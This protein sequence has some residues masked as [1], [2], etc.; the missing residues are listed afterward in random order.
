MFVH[1]HAND[2]TDIHTQLV[3]ASSA[4]RSRIFKKVAKE[5][6]TQMFQKNHL[7]AETKHSSI[8]SKVDIFQKVPSISKQRLIIEIVTLA[9]ALEIHRKIRSK[10]FPLS[11]LTPDLS[12]TNLGG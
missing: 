6:F 3:Y 11:D 2:R 10:E 8:S 5:T 7:W 9:I 12:D 4:L 1:I